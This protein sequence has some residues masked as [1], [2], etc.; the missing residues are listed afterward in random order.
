M[1][2]GITS[3]SMSDKAAEFT[4]GGKTA[5]SDVL[6][7]NHLIG[8][9]SSQGLPDPNHTLVPSLHNFTYDV[10]FYGTNLQLAENL[11]FDLAQFFDN[12]GLMFGTQCQIVN[13]QQW[14]I[15]DNVSS[16]W[17]STGVPCKPVENSWN[18]LTI[19]LERTSSN[20]LL[21]K[22]ITLNGVTNT[23]NAT[24]SPFSVSGWN[25]VVVNFQLDGNYA[26]QSYSVYLDNL[27][28]TYY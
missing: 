17:V 22:S 18:H 20:D 16:K 11:E 10:Y 14:G 24:Y 7:N 8:D 5:Y 2:Q 1:K 12:L 28:V 13:G 3:P 27:T 9:N 15:W 26:Q 25:G 23:L 21:Y 4:I 19:Q 6:W